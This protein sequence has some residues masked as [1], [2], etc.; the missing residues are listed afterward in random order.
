VT[1]TLKRLLF[2][3]VRV[4]LGWQWLQAGIH[5]V[6]A[7]AWTGE[8]AGA[9][10]AGF[11]NGAIAKA[12]GENPVVQGW[13]ANFLESW[14]LPNTKLFGYLVAYGELLVGIGLIIGAFTGF[15]A[16][17]GAL[18]NLNFML[19]GTLST[20]PILYTAAFV[21]LAGINYAEYY[22]L[23]TYLRP[24]VE[25]AASA[26]VKKLKMRFAKESA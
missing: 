8:N 5:K 13:Y 7:P 21:V 2:G 14:V 24:R 11:V 26:G 4:W 19:A 6:G 15:A 17:A 16:L 23:D 3:V 12:A 20:N 18:M 9:A 22:G 1:L 25:H 10:V